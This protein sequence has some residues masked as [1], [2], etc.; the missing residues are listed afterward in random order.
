MKYLTNR[1]CGFN[2]RGVFFIS[3]IFLWYISLLFQVFLNLSIFY[4]LFGISIYP[5]EQL[6]TLQK[7][8]H[9]CTE[10][11]AMLSPLSEK[12]WWM[13]AALQQSPRS[14]QILIQLFLVILSKLW[15]MTVPHF[16]DVP[17][18]Q[19]DERAIQILICQPTDLDKYYYFL[20]R[21]E[22]V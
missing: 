17:A 2:C 13:T 18:P 10:T 12:R 5:N 15:K 3:I 21:K 16:P 14:I 11:H 8:F 19:Q 4:S 1:M 20:Y 7:L 22:G 9:Y 6:S